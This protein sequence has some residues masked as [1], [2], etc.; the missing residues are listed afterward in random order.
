MVAHACNPCYLETKADVQ[1]KSG[2]QN[3]TL[4][5]KNENKNKTK[6]MVM[7]VIFMLYI[8]CHNKRREKKGPIT[9]FPVPCA[10]PIPGH[11]MNSQ[12]LCP[13][14]E[15]RGETQAK[16]TE[17]WLGSVLTSIHTCGVLSFLEATWESQGG[18]VTQRGRE[19]PARP[20]L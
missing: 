7:M 19:L 13:E 8:L 11:S 20:Q 6:E 12:I 3:K 9:L 18:E 4:S 17:Y 1:D 5:Q 14:A 2:Q 16:E 10:L 15:D